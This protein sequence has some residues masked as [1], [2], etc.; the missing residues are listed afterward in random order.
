MKRK[1][2]SVPFVQSESSE[3]VL[4]DFPVRMQKSGSP[5]TTPSFRLRSRAVILLSLNRPKAV[6]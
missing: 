5:E 3:N 6:P 1:E 2:R 4:K